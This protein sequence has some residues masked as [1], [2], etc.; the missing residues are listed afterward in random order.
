MLKIFSAFQ[1][2]GLEQDTESLSAISAALH[3]TS[4]G[5]R[6]WK[7]KFI[8]LLFGMRDAVNW[9]SNIMQATDQVEGMTLT[10]M[11]GLIE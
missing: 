7:V 3:L 4:S 2:V 11:N 6:T 9:K 1:H 8:W 10:L 5:W